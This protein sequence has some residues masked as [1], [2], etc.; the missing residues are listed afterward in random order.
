MNA[1]KMIDVKQNILFFHEQLVSDPNHRFRSWEHCFLHYQNR[2][3]IQSDSDIEISALHLAFYLASWGMY[4]GSSFLLK[5]DYKIHSPIVREL[6][7]GKYET[8]WTLDVDAINSDSPEVSLLFDLV[9]RIKRIYRETVTVI[10][11]KQKSGSASDILVTKILL[12][13]IGCIPA[14]DRLFKKGVSLLGNFPAQLGKSSY[15]GLIQFYNKNKEGIK[16]AQAEI[17]QRGIKYPTMKLIDMYF[18]NLG[19]ATTDGDDSDEEE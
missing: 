18:W 4:R 6:L 5:K 1:E 11:G 3:T 19:F 17:A 7:N 8:L 2:K 12:G 14:Y 16:A 10:D 13:T 9:T 15:A